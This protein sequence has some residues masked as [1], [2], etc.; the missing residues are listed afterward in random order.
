MVN[1]SGVNFWRLYTWRQ[2][3]DRPAAWQMRALFDFITSRPFYRAEP[4]QNLLLSPADDANTD[5]HTRVQVC[6]DREK[7]FVAAYLTAGRI[8]SL[9]LSS[10]EDALHVWWWNP[11]DGKT[12]YASGQESTEPTRLENNGTATQFTPPAIGPDND[13][14]LLLENASAYDGTPGK[15]LLIHESQRDKQPTIV[16]QDVQ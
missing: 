16:F 13:W 8:L 9:N 3:L 11:R 5:P 7:S 1:E 15:P 14:I 6:A 2:A 4:A 10:L 12:Y